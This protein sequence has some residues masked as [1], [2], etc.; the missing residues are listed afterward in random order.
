MNILPIHNGSLIL[1]GI[2]HLG[3]VNIH[4]EGFSPLAFLNIL[5]RKLTRPYDFI[6]SSII[7]ENTYNKIIRIHR[8]RI[9]QINL[10]TPFRINI[11][12]NYFRLEFNSSKLNKK[13][14]INRSK[15]ISF[16]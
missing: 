5:L 16:D 9:R 13:E 11:I 1:I 6:G 12:I 8:L 2:S 4:P 7:I 15:G 10:L 3:S 14:R